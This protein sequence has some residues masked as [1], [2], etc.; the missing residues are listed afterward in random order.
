MSEVTQRKG[1][2]ITFEGGEGAGKTTQVGLLQQRLQRIG[3]ALVVTREPGGTA[4]GERLRDIIF[5]PGLEGE[6]ELLL[7]LAARAQLLAEVIRPALERGEAIICDRYSDSTL[8]YQGYGR[9]LD[10][11]ATAAANDLATGGLRPDLSILLDLPVDAGLARKAGG[12]EWDTIGHESREFHERVRHGF[13][14]LAAA[15]PQRWL[16]VDAT[17]PI[18]DVS[19]MI[20]ERVHALTG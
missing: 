15:E 19:E 9:G 3:R 8:A 10:L 20:W 14:E 18:E 17:L 1:L 16:I 2:F 13:H 4:L 11:A 7:I 6:T 12:Y 5:R